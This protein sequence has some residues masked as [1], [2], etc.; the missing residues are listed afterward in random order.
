[1]LSLGFFYRL[2]IWGSH[3]GEKEEI[4]L[5]A[6]QDKKDHERERDDKKGKRQCVIE[7]ESDR[8]LHENIQ[9]YWNQ[10]GRSMMNKPSRDRKKGQ[11]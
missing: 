2:N 10:N 4:G 11:Q 8:N 7:E 6:I 5:K 1:M 9:K 3:F